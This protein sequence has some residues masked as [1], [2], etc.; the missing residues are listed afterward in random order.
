[1]RESA[2][3]AETDWCPLLEEMCNAFAK[4]TARVARN[5]AEIWRENCVLLM[6]ASYTSS[7]SKSVV[8]GSVVL[9]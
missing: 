6:P 7:L 2:R 5:I 8:T 9:V 1:M 4:F 3:F